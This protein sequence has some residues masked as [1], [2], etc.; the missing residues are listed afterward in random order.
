M[1]RSNCCNAL[2]SRS[3]IGSRWSLDRETR[4][5]PAEA[6]HRAGDHAGTRLGDGVH[7]GLADVVAAQ[8]AVGGQHG[9]ELAVVVL[10]TGGQHLLAA[11]GEEPAGLRVDRDALGD[12]AGQLL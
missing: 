11:E 10:A 5:R 7:I 4:L 6:A 9:D 3:S 12:A 2:I 1:V 8:A